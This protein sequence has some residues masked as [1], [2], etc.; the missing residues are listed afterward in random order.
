MSV[1]KVSQGY[2]VVWPLNKTS[3]L[4]RIAG[5]E[6][7]GI[8]NFPK[9]A[10]GLPLPLQPSP[11]DCPLPPLGTHQAQGYPWALSGVFFPH[12]LNINSGFVLV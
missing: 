11:S 1:I 12:T 2:N 8:L 10:P 4:E 5:A 9:A 7:L 6:G 3:C